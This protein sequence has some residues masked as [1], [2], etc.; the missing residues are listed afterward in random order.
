MAMND[1]GAAFPVAA[2]DLTG[3]Y[4]AA[5]GMSLRDWFAGQALAG[6]TSALMVGLRPPRS[7]IAESL[8]AAAYSCAGAMLAARQGA[9]ATPGEDSLRKMLA[10]VLTA[11]QWEANQGD[12]IDEQ[13]AELF[14]QAKALATGGGR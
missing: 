13:H 9:T 6:F 7:E 10:Q 8:A 2:S 3:S 11:W 4:P 12:G 14:A 1:G 5:P